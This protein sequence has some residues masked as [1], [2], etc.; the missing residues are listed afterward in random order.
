[1][2]GE[3]WVAGGLNFAGYWGE[4]ELTAETL[5]DGWVRTQDI[6]HLDEDGFLYIVDRRTDMIIT[7]RRAWNVYCRP[8]E[9][10]LAAHPQVRAAA[11]IGA[12]DPVDGEVVH[13]YVVP[14][15][16]ATV[17][18]EELA[19]TVG[20][21]LN[22]L[23]QPRTVEFLDALPLTRANKIDKKALRARYAAAHPAVEAHG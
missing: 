15:R 6:G 14:V 21:E 4:P 3:I 20:A 2:D 7:R 12:P 19:A 13:A 5:V 18:G 1:V 22:D 16:D 11:V 17:T 10:V 8:I 23:W 9:D